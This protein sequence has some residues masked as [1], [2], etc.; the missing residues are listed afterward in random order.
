MS[1]KKKT[2]KAPVVK[3]DEP[4]PKKKD[5]LTEE[6]IAELKDTFSKYDTKG[7]GQIPYEDLATV[8]RKLGQ[9]PSDAELED[10]VK[11]ADADDNG[12]ISF[13]EFANFMY[14]MM[15]EQDLRDDLMEAIKVFED[16]DGMVTFDDLKI[17]LI[18]MGEKLSEEEVEELIK[19]AGGDLKKETKIYGE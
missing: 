8:I 15:K 5:G 16:M 10:W 6:Q 11:L 9:N 18:E 1:T 3:K 17:M 2:T 7:T 19:E 13:D 12:M 4:K 14:L